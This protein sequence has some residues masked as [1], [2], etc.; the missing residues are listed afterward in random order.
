MQ[1]FNRF[2]FIYNTKLAFES[3]KL[4]TVNQYFKQILF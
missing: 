1:Y 2:N 4:N 3:E